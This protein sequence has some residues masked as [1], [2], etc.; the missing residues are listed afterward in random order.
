MGTTFTDENDHALI[1]W[2]DEQGIHVEYSERAND[3]FFVQL[4]IACW[5]PF[6]GL[7]EPIDLKGTCVILRDL[8]QS[9]GQVYEVT[10]RFP[11]G[12]DLSYTFD[13][14]QSDK[15]EIFITGGK[16][17][18]DAPVMQLVT[19]EDELPVIDALE[20]VPQNAH[21]ITSCE[22]AML[23]DAYLAEIRGCEADP[24]WWL[25]YYDT[26]DWNVAKENIEQE[27]KKLR[28]KYS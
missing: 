24:L 7:V 8:L 22:T 9:D 21:L 5:N 25:Q 10:F 3:L 26:E 15:E 28:Q 12:Y 13:G 4:Y 1:E 17:V 11:N 19:N 20:L 2:L 14:G 27:R 18:T 23:E 16:C 6:D